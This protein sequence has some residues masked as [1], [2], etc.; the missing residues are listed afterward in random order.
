MMTPARAVGMASALQDASSCCGCQTVPLVGWQWART[1][2]CATLEAHAAFGR[3]PLSMP[4]TQLA[5]TD[6]NPLF[7]FKGQSVPDVS[8]SKCHVQLPATADTVKV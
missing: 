6:T 5:Y 8:G 2:P 3:M 7:S 1:L 4:V